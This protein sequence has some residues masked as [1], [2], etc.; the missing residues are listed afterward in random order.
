MSLSTISR[1]VWYRHSVVSL[2]NF[3][4][5]PYAIV[6]RELLPDF[7]SGGREARFGVTPTCPWS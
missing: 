3:M 7:S 2:T 6:F 5:F 1:V 4:I